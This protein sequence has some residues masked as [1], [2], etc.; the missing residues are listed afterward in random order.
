MLV[1]V[2]NRVLLNLV[3]IFKS[4]TKI[5]VAHLRLQCAYTQLGYPRLRIREY[6]MITGLALLERERTL[7]PAA[8]SG[9][10]ARRNASPDSG[11]I[12]PCHSKDIEARMHAWNFNSAS[13]VVCITDVAPSVKILDNYT[14]WGLPSRKR[15]H[16]NTFYHWKRHQSTDP[17]Q[18]QLSE[19]YLF[20]DI[21]RIFG[22]K[23]S[24]IFSHDKSLQ[25]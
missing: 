4:N 14:L 13:I 24:D 1:L 17:A 2:C 6:P 9:I 7:T 23:T 12:D 5:R 18:L 3:H 25:A 20:Q 19:Y 21:C 11:E 15:V 22:A 8:Y 10:Y 16:L